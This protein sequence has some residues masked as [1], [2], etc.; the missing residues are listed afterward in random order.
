MRTAA[1]VSA[2][3]ARV[4]ALI[5]TPKME[6]NSQLN[7]YWEYLMRH[8]EH[9]DLMGRGDDDHYSPEIISYIRTEHGR[10]KVDESMLSRQDLV[11]TYSWAIPSPG[12]LQFIVEKSLDHGIIDIIEMG[13]GTGYWANLIAH[14]ESDAKNSRTGVTVLAYDLHPPDEDVNSYHSDYETIVEPL[15]QEEHDRRAAEY[16]EWRSHMAGLAGDEADE[17]ITRHLALMEEARPKDRV[18]DPVKMRR[19]VP[20]AKRETFK[21]IN[22]ST[23]NFDELQTT[24]YE[25]LFLCWPP[26]DEPMAYEALKAFKGQYLWYIGEDEGG[27]TA[28]DDFFQLLDSQWEL[29]ETCPEFYS[30]SGLHDE[31]RL[32]RRK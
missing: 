20:G 31:L 18:G 28:G 9:D 27:C 7:P 25:A 8:V 3:T 23:E 29:I 19:P 15:T 1:E 4:K 17:W 13:A 22:R 5:P 14:Q 11:K 26:Y 2:E 24:F 10:L 6:R 21:T 32:Y 12:A 30:W 16:E